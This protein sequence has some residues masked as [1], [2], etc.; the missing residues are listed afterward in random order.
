MIH[1]LLSIR[2]FIPK[3][4]HPS[5]FDI[6]FA[7]LYQAG[8]R[9]IITDLDNTLISYQEAVPTPQIETRFRT[10]K[11]MGFDIVLLSNNHTDR[12]DAFVASLNVKGFANA[13]KPLL[14]GLKKALR[15][16]PGAT[17]KNT[18]VIGDQLVTDILGANRLGAYAILVNP[19]ERKTE[20]WYTRMNR[21]L[22]EK[23]LAKIARQ[24]PAVFASLGLK[25][26]T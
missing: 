6:D 8:Y 25:E 21:R 11:D 20:K 18:L 23:M 5:V 3:E 24:R 26:R 2:P 19:I 12:I 16:M 9:H 10:L 13:R 7:A 4:F 17:T 22:E 15:S 1:H 14:C